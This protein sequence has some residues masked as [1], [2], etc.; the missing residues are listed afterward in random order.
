MKSGIRSAFLMLIILMLCF[1][2]SAKT[3]PQMDMWCLTAIGQAVQ[4]QM[5]ETPKILETCAKL[6]RIYGRITPE[7]AGRWIET[8]KTQQAQYMSSC[9]MAREA[10]IATERAANSLLSKT[11]F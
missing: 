1:N 6:V 2:R 4:C 9:P 3:E 7:N 11:G 10:A 5:P 8:A